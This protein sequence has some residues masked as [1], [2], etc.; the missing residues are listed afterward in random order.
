MGL[1]IRDAAKLAVAEI[2][3][4]GGILGRQ[5]D[6]IERD[7]QS[8]NDV[9]AKF[10]QEAVSEKVSGVIGFANSGVAM[11]SIAN[12]QNAKI[13]V[14][15]TA[16]SGATITRAFESRP[17]NYVFRMA[18][19]DS[20]MAP[21]MVEDS[22]VRRG[23]KKPAILADATGYGQ[24]GRVDL[25]QSLAFKGMA[26]VDTGVFKLGDTDMTAQL[27]KAKAAGADVILGYGIGPE[28]AAVANSSK[29]IGWNVPLVAAWSLSMSSFIDN[30]GANG[31]GARMPQTF[32]QNPNS[33]KRKAFIDS[34]L[35]AYKPVNNRIPSAVSA[36]QSYDAVY[37]MAAAIKQ[38][39]SVEGPKVL[40]ALENLT[41]PVEG[42]VSIYNRPFTKDD[43]EAITSN[44]LVFGE[45]KAGRVVFANEA[46][47]KVIN[48]L[49][50]STDKIDLNKR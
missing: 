9:G 3:K 30:A 43:H 32:I 23:F 49:K 33:P 25:E 2:N 8:K 45:V 18:A 12:F 44:M 36:G 22:I 34:Y 41:T 6:L 11:A 13:P 5:V 16:A 38:A 20:I 10:S 47:V 24:G 15:I 26:P 19:S 7:D 27:Q 40:K 35:A 48:R 39:G 1:S 37:V 42:V 21:M 4:A 28:L 17:E 31:D 46:D 29:K 14:I 50:T